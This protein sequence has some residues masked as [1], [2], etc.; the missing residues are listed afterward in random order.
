MYQIWVLALGSWEVVLQFNHVIR[1]SL[2]YDCCR[3]SGG[4]VE[5]FIGCCKNIECR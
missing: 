5:G 1:V 3:G 4:T 2:L